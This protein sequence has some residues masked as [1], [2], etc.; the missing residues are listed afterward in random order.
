MLRT[1][2]AHAFSHLISDFSHANNNLDCSNLHIFHQ[3]W[4]ADET[5][6][7]K[8]LTSS[9]APLAGASPLLCFDCS[10]K[11]SILAANPTLAYLSRRSK[12]E[13]VK[14]FFKV[15][16]KSSNK[17]D[18]CVYAAPVFIPD[19]GL[20]PI[21]V[22]NQD[23]CYSVW[24]FS[25]S[26]MPNSYFLLLDTAK[27]GENETTVMDFDKPCI[28]SPACPQEDHS[29]D[30]ILFGSPS[31]AF[32]FYL[33]REC[34]WTRLFPALPHN[35]LPS[36]ILSF[37]AS[38]TILLSYGDEI[39]C[40]K[41][42]CPY[43]N[44]LLKVIVN[45]NSSLELTCGYDSQILRTN[46]F[47]LAETGKPG[48]YLKPTRQTFGDSPNSPEPRYC[49][50]RSGSFRR[51]SSPPIDKGLD[52]ATR[53]KPDRLCN[54]GPKK[55][56]QRVKP[57]M[58]ID[59]RELAKSAS[60]TPDVRSIDLKKIT[61]RQYSKILEILGDEK[62]GGVDLQ[63]DS[64]ALAVKC[65]S[66]PRTTTKT[67]RTTSSQTTV[68]TTVKNPWIPPIQ[69]DFKP[70]QLSYPP[71]LPIYRNNQLWSPSVFENNDTIIKNEDSFC[72]RVPA[73]PL[74]SMPCLDNFLIKQ[75]DLPPNYTLDPLSLDL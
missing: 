13:Y 71:T 39:D 75:E 5:S 25:F 61:Q 32:Q 67:I 49:K 17:L 70:S 31:N 74:T 3:A 24:P 14:Y 11:F 10:C 21:L 1:C 27:V 23:A 66:I 51:K 26:K 40:F 54:E 2:F 20:S 7:A 38:P 47:E 63:T 64:S 19:H 45:I 53:A 9:F 56:W 29:V 48:P 50:K 55:R 72:P 57:D 15:L 62:R 28:L 42:E 44:N 58:D 65:M 33:C 43:D 36:E 30:P 6:A 22:L 59:P 73:T 69:Q 34:L 16:Q 37:I 68:K 8:Y 60:K 4:Y 35:F 12:F 18:L 46:Y 52:I 41:I